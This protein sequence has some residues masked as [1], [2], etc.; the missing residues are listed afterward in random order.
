M[1]KSLILLPLLL[2]FAI[3]I[4]FIFMSQAISKEVE[5]DTKQLGLNN[6]EEDYSFIEDRV[7]GL[8]TVEHGMNKGEFLISVNA[9]KTHAVIDCTFV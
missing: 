8:W 9:E 7:D 1:K 4:F 2:I 6:E 3:V 5:N